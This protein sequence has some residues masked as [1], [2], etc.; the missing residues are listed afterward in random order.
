MPENLSQ[1]FAERFSVDFVDYEDKSNRIPIDEINLSQAEKILFM[2]A[3]M[4][5]VTEKTYEGK[6]QEQVQA[7]PNITYMFYFN[8]VSTSNNNILSA[9]YMALGDNK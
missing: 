3:L 5:P 2:Q 7:D 9:L 1:W 8:V 6:T 4:T